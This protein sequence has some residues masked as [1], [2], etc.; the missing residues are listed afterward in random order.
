MLPKRTLTNLGFEMHMGVNHLGHFYLTHKLWPLIKNAHKPRIINV[1]ALA[2]RGFK[3]P[4]N[5]NIP[6]DFEDLHMQNGYSPALAYSRSKI[7]NIL[8]TIQ[9]QKMMDLSNF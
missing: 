2:H 8:F 6:I 4:H 5:Q 3:Y 7:G 1:S 9:L